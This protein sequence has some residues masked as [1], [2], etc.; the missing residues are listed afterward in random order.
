MEHLSDAK[1]E[2]HEGSQDKPIKGELV[3]TD[4]AALLAK[5]N[6]EDRKSFSAQHN[7]SNPISASNGNSALGVNLKS[8]GVRKNSSLGSSSF[9][10]R[11]INIFY[12]YY[13]FLQIFN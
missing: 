13:C 4:R 1:K 10:D 9:F 12:I 6:V 3:K 7:P 2:N 8:S 5:N 11:Y